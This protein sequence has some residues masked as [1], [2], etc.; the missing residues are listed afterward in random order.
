MITKQ[1]IYNQ[2]WL[3][4]IQSS[5]HA[6][7]WVHNV[8]RDI[9]GNGG[10]YLSVLK[11]WYSTYP[12]PSN[13]KR[14]HMRK[15]LESSTNNDHRGA[16]NELCWYRFMRNLA[17][18]PKVIPEGSNKTPDFLCATATGV[19]FYCEVTTLNE[20][21]AD[22]KSIASNGSAPLNQDADILRIIRK[23]SVEK[24]E[25]LQYG[26][27]SQKG[28]AFVIFDYSTFSGLGTRRPATFADAFLLTPIGLQ[29]MM[30]PYLSVLIYVERYVDKGRCRI[31]TQQSALYHNPLANHQLH[32][33][34]FS[35]F[36]QYS[37]NSYSMMEP[38]AV[39]LVIS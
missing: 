23:A 21:N 19:E 18:N 34:I 38:K 29:E 15:L 5:A 3:N 27:E 24:A 8:I 39:D 22:T 33:D 26:R 10:V 32:T 13:G 11:E 30:K 36:Q 16:V 28:M 4:C 2:S 9:K 37:L 7:S 20:S 12:F 1:S 6:D 14:T 35:C 31:R 17:L 25:Q